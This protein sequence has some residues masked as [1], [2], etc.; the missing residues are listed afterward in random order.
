MSK[1]RGLHSPNL[2][3]DPDGDERE[4]WCCECDRTCYSDRYCYCCLATEAERQRRRIEKAIGLH[5]RVIDF[6]VSGEEVEHCEECGHISGEPPDDEC[7]TVRA[8]SE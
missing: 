6:D 7:P 3:D 4:A 5:R 1:W 8:L 2:H